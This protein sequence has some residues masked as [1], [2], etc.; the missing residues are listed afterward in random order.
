MVFISSMAGGAGLQRF[1]FPVLA[2]FVPVY[3][4]LARGFLRIAAPLEI[5]VRDPVEWPQFRGRIAVAIQAES[6]AQGLIVIN[7]LHLV[8]LS[9]TF[10]A[11]D[12]TVDVDR[13]I[14]I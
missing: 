3:P 14:E 4:L 11:T 5:Q 10:H 6:H 1:H 9:V 7:L 8:N 2:Q 12:A 13:M